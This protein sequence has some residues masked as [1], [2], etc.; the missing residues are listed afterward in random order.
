MASWT[1]PRYAPVF[2]GGTLRFCSE[3]RR[4]GE[5]RNL[6]M[7]AAGIVVGSEKFSLLGVEPQSTFNVSLLAAFNIFM[8]ARLNTYSR[9]L[10]LTRIS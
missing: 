8:N 6:R 7:M 4:T 3:V 9:L 2:D 10:I 1:P 5:S